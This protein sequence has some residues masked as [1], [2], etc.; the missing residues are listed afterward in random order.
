M[1]TVSGIDLGTL[2]TS[3]GIVFGLTTTIIVLLVK[4]L[5]KSYREKTDDKLTALKNGYQTKIENL[6]KE[7]LDAIQDRKDCESR[8]GGSFL[9][10]QGLVDKLQDQWL[11][12]QK[13]AA[14]LEA[15][16][17]RR[18]DA[19]FNV[20]DHQ[21]NEVA[22]LRPALLNKQEDL[23]RQKFE[24]LKSYA[25]DFIRNEIAARRQG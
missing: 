6:T 17:G 2:L 11:E 24:E 7:L 18:L 10:L 21:K 13:S 16:R 22:Q 14:T 4:L 12:F 9:R 8:S 25:R 19:M 1:G 15:T 23:A 5:L 20:L 3:L